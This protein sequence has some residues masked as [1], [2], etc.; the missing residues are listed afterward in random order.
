MQC[1]RTCG[2]HPEVRR[3]AAVRIDLEGR[4]RQH[5]AFDVGEKAGLPLHHFPLERTGDAHDAVQQGAVG[6]VLITVSD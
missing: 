3:H 1:T 4:Q 6:K 5:G 2:R